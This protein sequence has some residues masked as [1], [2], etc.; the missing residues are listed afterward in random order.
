[1]A[2]TKEEARKEGAKSQGDSTSSSPSS[3]PSKEM[4]QDSIREEREQI[5]R[6]RRAL[7][8]RKTAGAL[9]RFV[10]GNIVTVVVAL[11]LPTIL[12]IAFF[13]GGSQLIEKSGP[14]K[15]GWGMA[16]VYIGLLL[17]IPWAKYMAPR[18]DRRIGKGAV[19]EESAS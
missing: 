11:F 13:M 15:W 17:N 5:R 6:E 7:S 8:A 10:R 14:L 4:K 16:A 18:L 3:P 9:V 2:D 12:G 1:M 19:Q